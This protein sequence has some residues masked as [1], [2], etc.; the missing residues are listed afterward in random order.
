MQVSRDNINK[1]WA[2]YHSHCKQLEEEVSAWGFKEFIAKREEAI[3][4]LDRRS[5]KEYLKTSFH[6]RFESDG[7]LRDSTEDPEENIREYRPF[8]LCVRDY[9][10]VDQSEVEEFVK[11]VGVQ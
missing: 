11:S 9:V 1:L 8:N 7:I 2:A 6:K 3:C 4:W 10:E 5:V